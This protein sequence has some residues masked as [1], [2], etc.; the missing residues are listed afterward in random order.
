MNVLTAPDIC[1]HHIVALNSAIPPIAERICDAWNKSR[2]GIIEAG[3]LLID[4]KA[5]IPHGEF[6]EM[7]AQELP[8]SHQTANKL[9]AIAK[10][11]RL[12]DPAHV[13]NL[14][15]SWGSLYEITKLKDDQFD[16][17]LQE[18]VI[19]PNMR[20]QKIEWFRERLETEANEI[21]AVTEPMGRPSAAYYAK[22]EK[23]EFMD[24]LNRL[25]LKHTPFP[26]EEMR[27]DLLS[28]GIKYLEDIISGELDPWERKAEAIPEPLREP[29]K[30]PQSLIPWLKL[31]GGL[32]EQSGELAFMGITPKTCP[33]LISKLG[34]T[35]DDA[36]L[37]AYEAGF[38]PDA[39]LRPTPSEL[40][41]AVRDDFE[42]RRQY[43]REDE[44][45]IEEWHVYEENW[46]EV[47]RAEIEPYGMSEDQLRAELKG[48]NAQIEGSP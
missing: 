10:D 39:A 12:Q 36:A 47:D 45:L 18:G 25:V 1:N 42:G 26:T 31:N 28:P 27:K 40:L 20:R 22:Q 11:E 4:A 5:A 46:R 14:P 6:A 35:H 23:E 8:F 48:H 7:I 43:R 29:K 17:A 33:G 15:I 2:E 44:A 32:M 13:R 9:M 30:K 16:R 34:R 21:G 38:F 3:R 19:N 37:A 41:D 24:G